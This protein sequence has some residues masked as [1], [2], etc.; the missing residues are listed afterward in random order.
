MHTCTCGACAGCLVVGFLDG[1]R[2]TIREDADIE[3]LRLEAERESRRERIRA[4]GIAS[5]FADGDERVILDGTAKRTESL[6]IVRTWMADYEKRMGAPWLWLG[7]PVGVG[8]TLAAA[9]AIAAWGGRYVSFLDVIRIHQDRDRQVKGADARWR[10]L[11]GQHLVVL[12]EVGLEEDAQ[13][14]RAR[15]ALHE[16]VEARRKRSTPT[17]ALTNKAGAV[18]RQRFA[19]DVY[20]KRTASRLGQVLWKDRHGSGL[21]DVGGTDLR[22]GGVL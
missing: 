3:A 11:G 4:S 7:G 5:H 18:I 9:H 16:F 12:D 13:L 20:D 19:A 22:G 10:R 14:S 2:P 6:A 8:K 17:I 1:F 15:V 21:H